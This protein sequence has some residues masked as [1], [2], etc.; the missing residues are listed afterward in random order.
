[1]SKIPYN[2]LFES[3]KDPQNQVLAR[4]LYFFFELDKNDPVENIPSN[5]TITQLESDTIKKDTT[6][7]EIFPP[8]K[9]GFI[10]P[11]NSPLK[12]NFASKFKK[13]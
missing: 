7:K 2:V 3:L 1:M 10:W 4:N 12:F 8:S 13:Y 9:G 6:I 5:L 11:G